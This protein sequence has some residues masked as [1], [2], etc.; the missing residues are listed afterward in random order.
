[1]GQPLFSFAYPAAGMFIWAKIDLA[2]NARYEEICKQGIDDPEREWTQKFW[3]A[4]TDA[5]VG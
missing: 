4:L 5:K 3:E 2:G 1:M